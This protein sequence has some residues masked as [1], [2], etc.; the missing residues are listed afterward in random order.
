MCFVKR[1]RGVLLTKHSLFSLCGV[2]YSVW[3]WRF[4]NQRNAARIAAA[5]EKKQM[6]AVV[7]ADIFR[8][9]VPFSVRRLPLQKI[10]IAGQTRFFVCCIILLYRT[11]SNF[12]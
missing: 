6:Y 2:S 8:F 4:D 9:T 1:R 10:K 12:P 11:P 7:A 3:E 5:R